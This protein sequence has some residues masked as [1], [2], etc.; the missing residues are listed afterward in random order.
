MR[1][2]LYVRVSN[3]SQV[4]GYSIDAQLRLCTQSIEARGWSLARVY[5]DEG[6][7]A[8]RESLDRPAL[9]EM[10]TAMR[11]GSLDAI[12]VYSIDRLSRRVRLANAILDELHQRSVQF[13]SVV[14]NLDTTTPHG[15]Y[16]FQNMAAQA[17]LYSRMLSMRVKGGLLEKAHQGR[18]VGTIPIGYDRAVDGSLRPNADAPVI[19]LAFELYASGHYSMSDLAHEL[20]MRGFT[21]K[22]HSIRQPFVRSSIR[23]ILQRRVYLGYVR[24]A[25]TEYAGTHEPLVIVDVWDDVQR[26]IAQRATWHGSPV[27][28]D[29]ALLAGQVWCAACGGKAHVARP[30]KR[31]LYYQCYGNRQHTCN[32][33]RCN[34]KRAEAHL[35]GWLDRLRVP[36]DVLDEALTQARLQTGAS[37]ITPPLVDLHA[38]DGRARRLAR[39]YADGMIDDAAYDAER[40]ALDQ[41]R[42]STREQVPVQ[43]MFDE[44]RARMVL[45]ALP[46]HFH[47]VSTQAQ[48]AY[49]H[50]LFDRIWLKDGQIVSVAPR[51]EVYAVVKALALGAIDAQTSVSPPI[52]PIAV[53]HPQYL[54]LA[55]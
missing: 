24:C 35:L 36:A 5:A 48:R 18:W 9:Q 47:N 20:N 31:Y 6:H 21:A 10:L 55:S 38:L 11:A 42:F 30:N 41:A 29:D 8:F 7:S 15:W 53:W 40:I 28:R 3:V 34:G 43:T 49:L 46:H 37:S 54:P 33:P 44:T 39:L 12:V 17:E 4:D 51:F 19:R 45:Q 16:M 27:R 26:I 1:A 2:G 25:G 22:H 52:A 23:N 50:A 14:E 32:Q 13:L